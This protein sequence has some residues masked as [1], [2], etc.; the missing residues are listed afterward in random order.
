MS[1]LPPVPP[2]VPVSQRPSLLRRAFTPAGSGESDGPSTPKQRQRAFQIL[3]LSLICLGVGQ[4][5]MFA[6]LPPVSRELGLT[7]FQTGAIFAISATIWVFSSAY[8]GARSDRQGRRPMIVLGLSAFS[9]SM[10]AFATSVEIGLMGILPIAIVYP[11]MIVSRSI[12]GIF[13]SA[14]F[15]AAQGYIADRTSPSERTTAVAT[16]NA[17]FGLGTTAGPGII[18]AL[19][20]MGTIAPLYFVAVVGA[21][22]AFVIWRFLPERTAPVLHHKTKAER[23]SWRDP[24]IL[25]FLIF[26]V[27]LGTAGSFPIQVI[28]YFFMD[29]LKLSTNEAIQL[30]GVGLMASSMAA[31]FAQLVIVQRMKLSASQLVNWGIGIG[32]ASYVLFIVGETYGLIVFALLLSGLG[33]GLI[34]PGYAAAASLAVGKEQQGA[35]AGL[36]GGATASGFIFAPLVGNFIYAYD[37]HAPFY[38]GGVLMIVMAIYVALSPHL[39]I[40]DN[41][42][43]EE[44]ETAETNV[45]KV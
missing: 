35:A 12:Y 45:P 13:G 30:S 24:R 32:F 23:L 36:T 15:P 5:G 33:F 42:P 3:F 39:R 14:G 4:S 38:L 21:C 19:A 34:R 8:W 20:V 40:L 27:M 29:V 7:E 6:I 44:S 26:G 1:D 10:L 31:L 2:E 37:P 16:L 22:S 28:A 9:I 11:L 43:Q 25:P 18:A 41:Q 17:A